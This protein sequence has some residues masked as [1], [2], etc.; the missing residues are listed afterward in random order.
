MLDIHE[1]QFQEDTVFVSGEYDPGEPMVMYHSDM[2]GSPGTPQSFTIHE[3]QKFE[4][5]EKNLIDNYQEKEIESIEE[6]ILN[7]FYNE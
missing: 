3:I 2:S 6:I 4:T 1:I 7:R 5:Q